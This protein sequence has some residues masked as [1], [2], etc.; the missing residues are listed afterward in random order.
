MH[1]GVIDSPIVLGTKWTA[2][3]P[4]N[5]NQALAICRSLSCIPC[6]A[7]T[8]TIFRCLDH[9][10]LAGRAKPHSCGSCNTEGV[11]SEGTKH[12]SPNTLRVGEISG[13]VL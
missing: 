13:G 9:K 3:H 10:V 11:R 2:S 4:H 8:L 5:G 7:S 6:M 12:A 1:F